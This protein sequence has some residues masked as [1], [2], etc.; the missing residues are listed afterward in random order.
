M[1]APK[2]SNCQRTKQ[3]KEIFVGEWMLYSIWYQINCNIAAAALYAD[4]EFVIPA[5]IWKTTAVGKSLGE[6]W[7]K[8]K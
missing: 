7:P 4:D 8:E 2:K 5:E 6:G 3:K 1:A